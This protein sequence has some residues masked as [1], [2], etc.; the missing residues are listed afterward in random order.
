MKNLKGFQRGQILIIFSLALP[1][2]IAAIALGADVAVLY[3]NWVQLQKAADTAALAGANY[4]PGD[5]AEAQTVASSNAST[6]GIASSEIV[7]TTVAPDDLSI[8]VTLQRTVM[9]D[10]ARVLG[11]TSNV[12]RT[13]ATAG[14]QSNPDWARGVMP[15]GLPCSSGSCSYTVG[16]SYTLKNGPTNGNWGQLG[17]G[18][19]GALA[20]GTNGANVYRGNIV[21]G[22]VGKLSVGQSISVETGNIVGPTS[23]GFTD[24][25]NLG[26]TLYPGANPANPSQYDPRL[27]V[28]PEVDFTGAKGKSSMVPIQNFALM[29]VESVSGNNATINAVYEGTLP[30]ADLTGQTPQ[31]FGMLTP[32]L[33]R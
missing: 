21:N 9:A 10:F 22:Y 20:L 18:N 5:P 14:I 23:Q 32:I 6:N 19:W 3:F 25:I 12:V 11:I 2:L 30:S 17:P 26:N 7:S 4:L 16:Q 8:T 15:V 1:V 31:D 29:F 28:V 33:L 24:R 13:A 27:V